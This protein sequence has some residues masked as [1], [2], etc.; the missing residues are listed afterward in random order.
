MSSTAER[1]ETGVL[2]PEGDWPGIFI[3]GDD[4]LAYANQLRRLLFDV[5]EARARAGNISPEEIA[6]WGKL[7]ELADLL[8]SCR[9]RK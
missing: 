9:G 1:L 8:A 7:N 3:R 2:K 4:A 6:A 5:L